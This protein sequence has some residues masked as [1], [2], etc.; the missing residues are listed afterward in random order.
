MTLQ[1]KIQRLI[2]ENVNQNTLAGAITWVAD[3]YSMQ[4]LSFISFHE[5][6]IK[7]NKFYLKD[8]TIIFNNNEEMLKG[9]RMH[10][11]VEEA[12]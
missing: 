8:G 7:E 9:F 1:Q 5:I 2:D 6:K 10:Y 12:E 4:I 11:H 3:D